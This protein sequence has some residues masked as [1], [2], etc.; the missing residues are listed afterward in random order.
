MTKIASLVPLNFLVSDLGI[1]DL[2]EFLLNR[3]MDAYRHD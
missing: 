2:C 1:G 3:N